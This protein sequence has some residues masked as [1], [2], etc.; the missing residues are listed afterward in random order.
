M[1]QNLKS[2]GRY[3]FLFSVSAAFTAQMKPTLFR[4]QFY[5]AQEGE[6]VT[7]FERIQP[8][9]PL[10][11]YSVSHELKEDLIIMG[12]GEVKP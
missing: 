6:K 2:K 8:S 1:G 3:I 7:G 5:R 10:Q 11:V 9:K 4:A 12:Y